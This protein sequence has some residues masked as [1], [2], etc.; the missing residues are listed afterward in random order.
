ME[1][2]NNFDHI[3]I[4]SA[5]I[6]DPLMSVQDHPYFPFGHNAQAGAYTWKS[7]QQRG[8][9]HNPVDYIISGL[10]IVLCDI[11]VNLF[12]P[13]QRRQ[14]PFQLRHE[15]ILSIASS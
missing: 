4:V 10:R 12:K 5:Q 6:D 1:H 13:I 9:L 11:T 15:R 3:C 14:R 7:R 2:T 8:L